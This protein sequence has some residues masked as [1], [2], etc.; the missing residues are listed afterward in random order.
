MLQFH[1][2]SQIQ[3]GHLGVVLIQITLVVLDLGRQGQTAGQQPVAAQCVHRKRRASF[4][5]PLNVDKADNVALDAA[6]EHRAEPSNVGTNTHR[7][8]VVAV[9]QRRRDGHSRACPHQ[10]LKNNSQPGDDLVAAERPRFRGHG[11]WRSLRRALGRQRPSALQSSRQRRRRRR[12]RERRRCCGRAH[13]VPRCLPADR[14]QHRAVAEEGPGAWH[15]R[16]QG[17]R[18]GR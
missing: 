10:A 16:W 9:E 14:H 5:C 15:R 11:L 12:W 18:G 17:S 4:H 2:V 7:R 6:T 3:T 13:S 1:Q 8:L